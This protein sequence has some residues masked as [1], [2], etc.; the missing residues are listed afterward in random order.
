MALHMRFESLHISLSSSAKQQRE[1]TK[2]CKFWR[3]CTTMAN[4]SCL[5]FEL[6]AA[7]HI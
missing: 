7:L 3:T 5:A 6:N 2:S 4:F 1:I